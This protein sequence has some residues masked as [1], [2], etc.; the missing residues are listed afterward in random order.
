MKKKLIKN[1]G[2]YGR[3]KKEGTWKK[4]WQSTPKVDGRRKR[5]KEVREIT[6]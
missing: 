3:G 5:R 6:K 1:E 4:R 2:H